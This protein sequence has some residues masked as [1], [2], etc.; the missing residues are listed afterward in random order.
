MVSLHFS[1]PP[2]P[3]ARYPGGLT[4]VAV[5]NKTKKKH[6]LWKIKLGLADV[7]YPAVKRMWSADLFLPE[8]NSVNFRFDVF[9]SPSPLAN[10]KCLYAVVLQ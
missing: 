2:S 7:F 10:Q 4:V 9:L 8:S 6:D 3:A 1:S 5:E